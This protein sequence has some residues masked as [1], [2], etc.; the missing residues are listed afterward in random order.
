MKLSKSLMVQSALSAALLLATGGVALAAQTSKQP[1]SNATSTSATTHEEIGTVTSM[2]NSDLVLSH[3][4][5]GKEE[6]TTFKMDANTKK[7]GTIDK[8]ARVAVYFT[9]QNHERIATKV[10]AEPKKS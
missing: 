9:D 10:K 4:H 2:T 6:S 7:E 5:K 3:M 1:S 8:G